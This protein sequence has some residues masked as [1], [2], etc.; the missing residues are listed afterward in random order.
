MHVVVIGSGPSGVAAAHALLA[1]GVEVTVVDGGEVLEPHRAAQVDALRAIAPPWT[2]Q[3]LDGLRGNLSASR[4]GIAQKR[5]FGSDFVYRGVDFIRAGA[6]IHWSASHATGGLSHVWGAAVLPWAEADLAGW[7]ITRAALFDREASLREIVPMIGA[8]DDLDAQ[9][10]WAVAPDAALPLSRPMR[11]LLGHW[12]DNRAHLQHNGWRFGSARLAVDLK[13]CVRCGLCLHGCP[14]GSI[15]T[16]SA[17]LQRWVREGRVRHLPGLQVQVLR[18]HDDAIEVQALD[19]RSGEPVQLT[20]DRVFLA[21][22]TLASAWI[23]ARTFGRAHTRL[24]T[25]QYFLAPFLPEQAAR[26]ALAEAELTL[27]QAFLQVT[28]DGS[29]HAA[30]LQFYGPNDVHEAAIARTWGPLA[31]LLRPVTTRAADRLLSLQGYLHSADSPGIDA[32]LVDGQLQLAAVA[33]AGSAR[34]VEALCRQL[35]RDRAALGGRLLRP[36][37]RVGAAGEGAHVG[38]GWPMAAQPEAGQTD[39]LGRPP[40]WPRLHVVD[41]SVLPSVAAAT[42]TWTAMN[43]AARIAH[44]AP[45]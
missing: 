30:N 12:Q 19:R 8:Q 9:H 41:A 23:L 34:L 18:Q 35:H 31:R 6:D 14:R 28:P 44:E 2:T 26:G 17:V 1:R 16:A 29:Q 32:R 4:R 21:A 24:L 20:A 27:A 39:V 25:S 3:Q 36:L 10:P 15:W 11:Q 37:L 43:N 5:A 22:G 13:T 45:L 7:P 38:G 40:G 42:F 33:H